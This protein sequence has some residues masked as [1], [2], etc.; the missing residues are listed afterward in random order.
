MSAKQRFEDWLES[1]DFY[2]LC[3]NYRMATDVVAPKGH[4]TASEAFERLKLT[5][6]DHAYPGGS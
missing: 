4:D 6:M 3:Q 1:R 5:I 2:E